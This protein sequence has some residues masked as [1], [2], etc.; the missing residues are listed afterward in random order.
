MYPIVCFVGDAAKITRHVCRVNFWEQETSGWR[1]LGCAQCWRDGDVPRRLRQDA[2]G[3]VTDLPGSLDLPSA[4]HHGLRSPVQRRPG[5]PDIG[6]TEFVFVSHNARMTLREIRTRGSWDKVQKKYRWDICSPS[7]RQLTLPLIG[8]MRT[9]K[10]YPAFHD[11]RNSEVASIVV[12]G[13]P[14]VRLR[15]TGSPTPYKNNWGSLPCIVVRWFSNSTLARADPSGV[16]R[17]MTKELQE[18][19]EAA[20]KIE[21]SAEQKEEQ[22]R[23]FV[24][25]NTNIENPRITRET[26]N[27]AAEALKGE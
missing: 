4:T 24:F 6:C 17:T 18:L 8:F 14:L 27:K 20:K 16:R 22:R 11:S 12:G 1:E 9:G 7:E 19:L 25:G 13:E 23:S 26:V 15:L 10:F 21:M 5:S 3:F 2:A